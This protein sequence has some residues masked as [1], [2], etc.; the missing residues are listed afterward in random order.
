MITRSLL[1]IIMVV[2]ATL[3]A[4]ATDLFHIEDFQINPGQT[5]Q[6]EILLDNEVQYTAF[7]TDLYLPEGL[8]LD[9][10]SVA[11]TDRKVDHNI[12]TSVLAD[13]GIRLM[14]YSMTLKPYGGNSGALVT[15]Q[16][17]ASE[18]LTGPVVI[19]LKNT[20]FTTLQGREVPFENT[21]CTVSVV[22]PFLLGD[23]N[24]DGKVNVSDVSV[25]INSLMNGN[26]A[27]LNL[28]TADINGDGTVNI[29]DVSMLIN[30]IMNAV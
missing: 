4:A 28:Q 8:A 16:V 5:A 15:F 17:T 20:R 25:L 24:G 27:E 7:Q 6:V 21:S 18:T 2:A 1:S 30:Q 19:E 22:E 3:G 14:S 29:T 13:G 11:L 10:Q 9:K 26:E 12:A 23:V